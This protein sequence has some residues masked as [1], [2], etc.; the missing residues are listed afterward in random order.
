MLVGEIGISRREVLYELKL[1]EIILITR[2]Y[3]RRYHPGWEQARLIAYHAAHAMGCKHMPPPITQWM[4]L[5]W[6]KADLPDDEEVEEMRA[7]I[8]EEN[9]QKENGD[10]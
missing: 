10:S 4:Q 8:R 9:E 7:R 3:W 2:G 5:P 1:K 6:E